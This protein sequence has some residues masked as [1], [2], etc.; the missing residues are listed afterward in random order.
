MLLWFRHQYRAPWTWGTLG[1]VPPHPEQAFSHSGG[2]W[3]GERHWNPTVS[4]RAPTI[5]PGTATY[6][7][8]QVE[9]A[10]EDSPR[11]GLSRR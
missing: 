8:P 7:L 10:A 3:L 5:Q 9:L 4:P 2:W 1:E 6:R 11:T